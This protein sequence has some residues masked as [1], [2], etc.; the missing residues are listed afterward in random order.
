M[1]AFIVDLTA[2]LLL[3]SSCR[4]WRFRRPTKWG[5]CSLDRSRSTCLN[6]GLTITFLPLKTRTWKR[7]SI[8]GR[9]SVRE[10]RSMG[11][12]LADVAAENEQSEL[13]PLI[14]GSVCELCRRPKPSRTASPHRA[15]QRDK[16][17][18]VVF[19]AAILRGPHLR[20][21][22][23]VFVEFV[24]C[25]VCNA[26]CS[27]VNRAVLNLLH[28][29]HSEVPT[30][31]R[32]R[33]FACGAVLLGHES[34]G[35]ILHVLKERDWVRCPALSMLH[36]CNEVAPALQTK[37]ALSLD[38]FCF[39]SLQSGVTQPRFAGKQPQCRTISP[40]P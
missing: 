37:S 17:V 19:S 1:A 30:L 25:A 10:R 31:G 6:S 20:K 27:Q 34:E 3:F 5:L 11:M 14:H 4:P 18:A 33:G 35:S 7:P 15:H 29:E 24:W 2:V 40:K 9:P 26:L 36:L 38:C 23:H 22:I 21:T 28:S 8:R 39:F 16:Q 12:H 32:D 13:A